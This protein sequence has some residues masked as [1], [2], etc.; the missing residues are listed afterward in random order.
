MQELEIIRTESKINYSFRSASDATEFSDQEG[1][2]M[3]KRVT[4]TPPRSR[5]LF[6]VTE[7]GRFDDVTGVWE[8]TGDGT[9]KAKDIT[10][11]RN[12]GRMLLTASGASGTETMTS[13]IVTVLEQQFGRPVESMQPEHWERVIRALEWIGGESALFADVVQI[14]TAVSELK[15]PLDVRVTLKLK[16]SEY[17]EKRL[18]DLDRAL[19]LALDAQAMSPLSAA[20][21]DALCEKIRSLELG[22]HAKKAEPHWKRLISIYINLLAAEPTDKDAQVFALLMLSRIFSIGLKD[23]QAGRRCAEKALALDPNSK[24]AADQVVALTNED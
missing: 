14:L 10:A 11:T 4:I 7:Q 5:H 19:S 12:L 16:A 15:S 13:R 2:D 8:R 3:S 9:L 22:L 24:D 21:A 23:R 20:P 17:L 6:L 1:E 18:G